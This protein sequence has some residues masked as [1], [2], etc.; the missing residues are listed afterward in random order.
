MKGPHLIGKDINFFSYTNFQ[1]LIGVALNRTSVI[2]VGGYV[3]DSRKWTYDRDKVF[4][5]NIQNNIWTKYPDLPSN[6]Y[7]SDTDEIMIVAALTFEKEQQ[8]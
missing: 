5:V 2:L 4:I 3:Y 1:A 6:W 7:N 8:R